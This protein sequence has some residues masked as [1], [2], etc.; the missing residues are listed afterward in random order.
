[1]RKIILWLLVAYPVVSLAQSKKEVKKFDITSTTETVTETIDGKEVTHNDLIKKFDKHG[2]EIE[3]INYD[4]V[5]KLKERFVR[6]FDKNDNKIEEVTFDG[7][8]HQTKKE[9][10]KYD[11]LG[12]KSEEYEYDAKNVLVSK[13]V[14]V[15]DRRG[16]K[17]EKRTY[18][19]K[20]KLIQ[21]KRYRYED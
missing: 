2:N 19:A 4:K 12:E 10:Y 18:D 7:N 15:L 3:E 16:L 14:F 6:K 8:N 9:I 1:M 11:E 5:G 17:S 13:S 20:G 21:I